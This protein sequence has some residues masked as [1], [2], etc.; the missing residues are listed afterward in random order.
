MS[1]SVCR[2]LG[3]NKRGCKQ[4]STNA[5]GEANTSGAAN[6]AGGPLG[7]EANAASGPSF[8]SVVTSIGAGWVGGGETSA[9]NFNYRVRLLVVWVRIGQ[10]DPKQGQQKVNLH[11]NNRIG[12]IPKEFGKLNYLQVLDL[13][14]NQLVGPIPPEL[15]NCTSLM[16]INVESNVL[17]GELP[18]ELGNLNY[19]EELRLDR[20]KL[21]GTI[22]GNNISASNSSIYGMSASSWEPTGFCCSTQL[23]VANFSYNFFVGSI[24]KCLEN[25]SGLSF[26]GNCLYDIHPYSALLH[27]VVLIATN[28]HGGSSLPR[29]SP[30]RCPEMQMQTIYPYPLEEICEE[31]GPCD[32][33]HCFGTIQVADLSRLDHENAGKLLGYCRESNPFTR[34]LAFEYASNGTLYEHL[35]YREGCQLSWTR[36]MKIVIGIARGLRY[37]H[38]ELDP[39]FTISELNSSAVYLTDDFSPKLVDFESWKS[40][41][42]RSEKNAGSIGN[43]GAVCVLPNSLE[44]RHLDVRGNI[45]GFGVLLL[46]IV[47]GRPYCKDK[48]CFVDWFYVVDP[49]L[50][51]FRY[52]ELQTICEAVI[53][54]INPN[55][56]KRASMAELCTMLES[57]I[58]TSC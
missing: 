16:T 25:I 19:L 28:N 36:C 40:M 29:C 1:C 35:H 43:E 2:K 34:M 38:M 58:D 57:R 55:P 26:Q 8:N 50:K 21:R 56:S 37:F 10:V 3:H 27:N 14:M 22:P 39:P 9:V 5:G 32:S 4:G 20:N 48:G 6:A 18:P 31:Q 51:H 24:P 54:C 41:H 46:E 45:Y 49:E 33:I 47:S 53:L 42:S 52:D 30:H 11:G 23:E 12:A 15:G 7:G 13:G 17:T 44:E